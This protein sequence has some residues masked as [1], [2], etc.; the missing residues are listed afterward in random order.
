MQDANQDSVFINGNEMGAE[1]GAAYRVPAGRYWYDQL[2]GFWGIE[3]QPVAGQLMPGLGLGG[4]LRENASAGASDVFV[5]GRRLTHVETAWLQQRFG[6]A[7]PGRYW[8]NAMLYGGIE[9]FPASFYL[10]VQ[11]GG[12]QP[13]S[14]VRTAFGDIMSD[15]NCTFVHLPGGTSVGAGAC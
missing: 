3:G 6:Y 7:A 4:P 8:L 1:F 9:G 2:S 10:G 11:G 15:G 12:G 14:N 13:G 5:N